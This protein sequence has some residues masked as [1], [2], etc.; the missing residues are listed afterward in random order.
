MA[1]RGSRGIGPRETEPGK[2][3][4]VFSS[5]TSG[6]TGHRPLRLLNWNRPRVQLGSRGTDTGLASSWASSKFWKDVWAGNLCQETL[7]FLESMSCHVPLMPPC[8]IFLVSAIGRMM[9]TDLW[10]R[11]L[12]SGKF[13]QFNLIRTAAFTQ[14][15]PCAGHW[16]FMSVCSSSHQ[17]Q[18]RTVIIRVFQLEAQAG[19]Y[20]YVHCGNEWTK[21]ASGWNSWP[22]ALSSLLL[23]ISPRHFVYL[24]AL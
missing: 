2:S 18:R 23:P 13:T 16:W 10:V 4:I 8:L 21:T 17:T 5:L 9:N 19:L 14:Q 20:L 15:L 3:W 12:N 11:Q 7:H 1:A 24:L 22:P 6:V